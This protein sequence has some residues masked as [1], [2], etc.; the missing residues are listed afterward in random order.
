MAKPA[1]PTDRKDFA[2]LFLSLSLSYSRAT[3]TRAL[4]SLRALSQWPD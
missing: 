4:V 1:C 2:P 3:L